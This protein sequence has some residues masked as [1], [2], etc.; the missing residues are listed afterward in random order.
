MNTD[1]VLIPLV[2]GLVAMVRKEWPRI[3]GLKLVL[4]L[5]I[6]LAEVVSYAADA[7]GGLRAVAV[8]GLWLGFGALGLAS[9]AGYLAGKIGG[10][11]TATATATSGDETATATTV[12]EPKPS[13][14][15]S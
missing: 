2:M 9:G 13:G 1:A 6:V 14:G 12:T 3:D 5:T 15:G 7:S 8:R 11:T 10:S 4:P